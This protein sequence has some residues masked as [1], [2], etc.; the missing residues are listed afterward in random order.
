MKIIISPARTMKVDMDSLPIKGLPQFLEQSQQILGCLQELDM[1][2]L[3]EVW[4]HCSD[5]LAR[6]NYQRI[7]EMKLTEKLTPAVLA[8]QGLQYQY[9]GAGVMTEQE[10]NYLQDHL[11]IISGFY[12]LLRPFDGIRL[13]RLGMGDHLSVGQHKSLYDFW[14]KRI[15]DAL[16][17]QNELVVNLASKEYSKILKPYLQDNDRFVTCYF[18]ELVDGKFKQKT[19]LAKMA[20]GNMVRFMAENNVSHV[21]ILQRFTV[22]GYQFVDELSTPTSYYFSKTK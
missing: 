21:E 5:R 16:N 3:Q 12:G 4:G 15:Y 2:E 6:D 20:R 7:K 1:S 17:F 11:R 13:Y 14:G 19:T 8:F 22:G 9:I 10:L 18:G